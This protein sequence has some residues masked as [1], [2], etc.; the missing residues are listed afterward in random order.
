M[1]KVTERKLVAPD[2]H[3]QLAD[4]AK[5]RMKVRAARKKFLEEQ[6]GV[7]TADT[8]LKSPS[9]M[10]VD[11]LRAAL[12]AK[13]F[14]APK[15]WNK[16]Q[17]LEKMDKRRAASFSPTALSIMGNLNTMPSLNLNPK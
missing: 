8:Q 7:E 6:A 10:T 9:E 12:A 4:K 15:S 5:D 2:R 14:D 11:E 16:K 3:Q 13:G 17:L 1:V